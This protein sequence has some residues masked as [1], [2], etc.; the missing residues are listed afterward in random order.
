MM[1]DYGVEKNERHGLLNLE[2]CTDSRWTV[3]TA[4][5]ETF[6]ADLLSRGGGG[7]GQEEEESSDEE[8]Y[9]VCY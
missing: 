1:D 4:L 3:A 7:G 6:Q 2:V 9:I 5:R 8:N